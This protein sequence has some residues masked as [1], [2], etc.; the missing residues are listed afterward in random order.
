MRLLKH[1]P[2]RARPGSEEDT[3]KCLF[4]PLP[5]VVIY[6]LKEQT[7]EVLRIYQGAQDRT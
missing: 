1:S 2:H 4:A 3:R 6:R 7:I 5:Y